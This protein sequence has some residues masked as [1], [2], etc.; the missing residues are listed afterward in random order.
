MKKKILVIGDSCRDVHVYCSCDRMSP[1]KPVPV[2][3]ILDQND[4][5]GMA[6]NVYRNIKSLEDSCDIVTNSNWANITKTRYIHKSTNHMFFRLDSAENIKRFNIAKMD[7]NY[8][9]VVISD[10]NKGF[11]TEEDILT[12]SSNHNSVFLDSKRILGDWATKVRFVK[13]N[14]FEYDRSK[15]CVPAILKDKIIKTAAEDGCYYLGKN[16]PVAQ[17][18]VIDVSGAGDSFLAGLVVEFSKSDDMEKAIIFANECASR[19]VGQKGVGII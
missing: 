1:D 11:L 18:E 6:K 2:L 7:Y 10:Y 19:V 17:Q 9:H 5:P 14:N 4:N 16:Y 8:D 12:I 3:K 13:I 15:H